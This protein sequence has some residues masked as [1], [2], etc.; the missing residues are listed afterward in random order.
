M[1]MNKLFANFRND[2]NLRFITFI[3]NLQL[4]FADDLFLCSSPHLRIDQG[5]ASFSHEG[6]DLE[7]ML[8]LRPHADWKAR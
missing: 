3:S 1:V 7:K 8:K 2:F 6:P 5:W 4:I